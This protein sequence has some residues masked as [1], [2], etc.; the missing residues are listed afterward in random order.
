MQEKLIYLILDYFELGGAKDNVKSGFE[1][2]IENFM[3]KCIE[4]SRNGVK[5]KNPKEQIIIQ[6]CFDMLNY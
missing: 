3:T 4:L 6:K 5:K 1:N 2:I